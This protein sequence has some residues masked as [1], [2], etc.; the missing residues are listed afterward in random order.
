MAFAPFVGNPHA[1]EIKSETPTPKKSLEVASST[2]LKT[3]EK[4][5]KNTGKIYQIQ[6]AGNLR[7]WGGVE[8]DPFSGSIS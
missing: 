3:D 6:L 1:P 7:T 4:P 5:R 8:I 2:K